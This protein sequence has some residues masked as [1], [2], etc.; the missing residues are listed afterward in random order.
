MAFNNIFR[1]AVQTANETLVK[2]V[3]D[4]VGKMVEEGVSSVLGNSAQKVDPQE[5]AKKQAEEQKRRRTLMQFFD[6][7]KADKQALNQA[8]IIKQQAEQKTHQE[9]TRKYQV[10]QFEV[11]EKQK[12]IA[13]TQAQTS[14]E[15]KGGVSG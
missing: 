15:R 11:Q 1:G 12:S 9:E 3:Q 10:Q 7:F 4:E 2:P 8:Q 13:V 14:R 6:Q 5:E